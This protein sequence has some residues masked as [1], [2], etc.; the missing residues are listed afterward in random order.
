MLLGGQRSFGIKAMRL[1]EIRYKW[2]TKPP[3]QS[4][5]VAQETAEDVRPDPEASEPGEG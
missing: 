4:G 1:I 2:K 5:M 3:D